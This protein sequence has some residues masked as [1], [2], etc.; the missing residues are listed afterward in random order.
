[1]KILVLG[2]GAVG[3]AIAAKLSRVCDVHAVYPESRQPMPSM[4]GDFGD[5]Y[6]GRWDIRF[7]VAD[8]IQKATVMII[9]SS[10]PNQRTPKRSARQFRGIHP[11]DTETVSLQNGIGNEEIISRFTDTVIGGMIITG[12]EWQGDAGSTSPSRQGR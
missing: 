7:S 4:P 11:R 1:M 3:L 8:S 2:A 6:L 10:L 12:F 9:S 5:R